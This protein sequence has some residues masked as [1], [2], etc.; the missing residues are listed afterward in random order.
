[1]VGLLGHWPL[2]GRGGCLLASYRHSKYTQ[3]E[4]ETSSKLS[5]QRVFRPTFPSLPY[6]PSSTT[7][8]LASLY[9]FH[10]TYGHM[11]RWP[12]KISSLREQAVAASAFFSKQVFDHTTGYI[13][14]DFDLIGQEIRL[15]RDRSKTFKYNSLYILVAWPPDRKHRHHVQKLST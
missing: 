9:P 7:S 6:S 11:T 4:R 15:I 8:R 1:V 12:A 3:R 10:T 14:G 2:M 5:T 13:T